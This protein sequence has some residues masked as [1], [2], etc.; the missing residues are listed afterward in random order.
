MFGGAEDVS[1][2]IHAPDVVLPV[3]IVITL[4][5]IVALVLLHPEAS[6]VAAMVS[7]PMVWYYYAPLA[8]PQIVFLLRTPAFRRA[9]L[10]AAGAMSAV[11][12]LVNVLVVWC[13]AAAP[14]MA[15]LLAVQPVGLL[16]LLALSVSHH[17]SARGISAL[18][19]P[20]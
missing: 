9:T 10:V 8:L 4:V 6:P 1:P 12:P 2:I 11:L 13:G 19:L 17:L 3:T 20:Q 15:A 14:P 18:E 16:L 5:A 7:L